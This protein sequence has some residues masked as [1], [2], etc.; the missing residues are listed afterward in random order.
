MSYL[1]PYKLPSDL[2][3]NWKDTDYVSPNGTEVALTEKHGYNY[4]MKQVNNAQ[5]SIMQLGKALC[6]DNNNLID[7]SF[8]MNPVNRKN[9]Y[10]A[11]KGTSY[12]K[13]D[14]YGMQAG[15]LGADTPAYV[16]DG[17]GYLTTGGSQY[18][19]KPE[20]LLS[21]YRHE[22]NGSFGFD[23]WWGKGVNTKLKADNS[24]IRIE[25]NS[26]LTTGVLKQP[27]ADP[28]LLAG[29]RVVF[30]IYVSEMESN[31]NN[32]ITIYKSS[33]VESDRTT[34]NTI[35][36]KDIS[37]GLN[38]IVVDLPTDV[39]NTAN[40]YLMVQFELYGGSFIDVVATKLQPGFVSTLAYQDDND[41]WHLLDV[42]NK[43]VETVR[44]NGA[45]VDIGGQGMIVTPA[46]IGLSAANVYAKAKVIE[47][48]A[49]N[50]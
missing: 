23:R 32:K 21:G 40:P 41:N 10:I 24:G 27:I 3:E 16:S 5:G 49:N 1:V 39:G 19:V 46:D 2:P 43:I 14:D 45:S 20:Q 11:P 37:T 42:P 48:E 12:Y 38:Y 28:K 22:A 29:R 50:E 33:K 8:F 9:G 30:S 18:S 15:S 13:D 4:L 7:N 36:N 17:I 34:Q 35:G 26:I 25:H 6:S 44:C 31:P 47:E